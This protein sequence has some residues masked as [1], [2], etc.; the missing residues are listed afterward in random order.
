MFLQHVLD[1]VNS[2]SVPSLHITSCCVLKPS[3]ITCGPNVAISLVL[4]HRLPV[5]PLAE[6]I[7]FTPHD[8]H[9]DGSRSGRTISSLSFSEAKSAM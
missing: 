8:D 1:Y 7:C 4:T 3:S 5:L 2:W 6:L 9:W